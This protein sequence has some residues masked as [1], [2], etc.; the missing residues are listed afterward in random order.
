MINKSD[1]NSN[2]RVDLAD[3]K[4]KTVQRSPTTFNHS[5]D[6]N[7]RNTSKPLGQYSSNTRTQQKIKLHTECG[8]ALLS[9]KYLRGRS[10]QLSVHNDTQ[11]SKLRKWHF[12]YVWKKYSGKFRDWPS[13]VFTWLYLPSTLSKWHLSISFSTSRLWLLIYTPVYLIRLWDPRWRVVDAI[14][15][16]VAIA[17]PG[18]GPTIPHQEMYVVWV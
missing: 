6:G 15:Q 2:E 17:W 11:N 1:W 4:L 7:R 5:K 16:L 8:G 10:R 12:L 9:S 18:A 13:L 3:K 14:H